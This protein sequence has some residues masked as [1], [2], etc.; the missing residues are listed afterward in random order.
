[1]W[2][3]TKLPLSR[4]QRGLLTTCAASCV[5]FVD[6]Y[7]LLV[8]Y[9]DLRTVLNSSINEAK[10][11]RQSCFDV[12]TSNQSKSSKMQ[13]WQFLFS[14]STWDKFRG[15]CQHPYVLCVLANDA[16]FRNATNF[17]ANLYVLYVLL[18][19]KKLSQRVSILAIVL[20]NMRCTIPDLEAPVFFL[21]RWDVHT[22]YGWC[23]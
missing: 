5:V 12:R 23:L 6:M 7:V 16:D 13:P 1:M 10:T 18:T 11:P 9:I 4:Q 20:H 14:S 15:S 22:R 21:P 17:W 3:L 8:V 19:V 2:R